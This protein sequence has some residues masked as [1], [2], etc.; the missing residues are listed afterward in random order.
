MNPTS[1]NYEVLQ[2]HARCA[3]NREVTTAL[4]AS[5]LLAGF[6]ALV[7]MIGAVVQESRA[8]GQSTGATE[9]STSKQQPAQ[10]GVLSVHMPVF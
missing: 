2:A 7:L 4:I 1:W 9:V 3:L 8:A 10:G 6:A 5:S